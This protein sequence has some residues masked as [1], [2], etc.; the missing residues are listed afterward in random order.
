MKGRSLRG[1]ATRRTAMGKITIGAIC[2]GVVLVVIIDRSEHRER[3]E[4]RQAVEQELQE[5]RVDKQLRRKSTRSDKARESQRGDIRSTTPRNSQLTPFEH[6]LRDRPAY[7]TTVESIE[8]SVQRGLFDNAR[9]EVILLI[10]S[11]K[12]E[13]DVP[14]DMKEAGLKQLEQL[15]RE[16]ERVSPKPCKEGLIW[17]TDIQECRLPNGCS[18]QMPYKWSNGTCHVMNE[19]DD[20]SVAVVNAWLTAQY[21]GG[22]GIE[23]W[24]PKMIDLSH[25]FFNV[26]GWQIKYSRSRYPNPGYEILMRVQSSTRGGFAI[27]NTYTVYLDNQYRIWALGDSSGVIIPP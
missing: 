15:L 6:A 23:Y 12:E 1:V 3:T 2:V 19:R 4:Q 13:L 11:V 25:N 21:N 14:S 5:Q 26:K 20:K 27:D 8:S 22:S 17:F 24:D 7:R 9:R 18:E 10:K 16:L